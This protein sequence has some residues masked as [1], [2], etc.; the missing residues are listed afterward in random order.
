[1][2]AGADHALLI[3][4]TRAHAK[5]IKR[6]SGSIMLFFDTILRVNPMP[7]KRCKTAQERFFR[8]LVLGYWVDRVRLL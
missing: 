5:S 4:K 1:M 3:E 2:S 6:A 8:F 7:L